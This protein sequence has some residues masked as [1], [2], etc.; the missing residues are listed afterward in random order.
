MQ[1]MTSRWLGAT[2]DEPPATVAALRRITDGFKAF[3][4]LRAGYATGLFDWLEANGPAERGAI[5]EA[6]TLRGAHLGAFMQAL[7]GLGLVTRTEEGYV[8]TPGFADVLCDVGAWNQ[9]PVVDGLL[10]TESGWGDLPRFMSEA[11]AAAPRGEVP[12]PRLHPF[13]GEARRVADALTAGWAESPATRPASVLCF[14]GGDGL[15]AAA[16]CEREPD[17]RVTVVV[18]PESLSRTERMIERAGFAANCRILSGGPL[19][20]PD[21]EAFALVVL[22]HGLYPVRTSVVDALTAVAGR[23]APGGVLCS[24]DWFCLEAC[25][26]G[27]GGL[28]DLDRAVLTDSHPLCH[29]ELFEDRMRQAGL[30]PTGQVSLTGEYGVTRL[31]LARSAEA[32]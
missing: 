27:P 32:A 30:V 25:E 1:T 19:T 22:F 13:L 4:A 18:T 10:E 21:L 7:E 2:R 29:V 26:I 31:H 24:A 28:R 17:L 20:Q 11:W 9:R 12:A 23:V 5:A 16:L 15:L 8:L 3:Q 14:D 6:L